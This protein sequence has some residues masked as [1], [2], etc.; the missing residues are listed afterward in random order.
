MEWMREVLHRVWVQRAIRAAL[1]AGLS[2]QAALMLPG[3]GGHAYYAPLGAVIAVH[4]TV[5]DS[6]AAAWRT[7][8][9]MLLGFVLAVGVYEATRAVPNAIT[10]ALIVVLAVGIEQWRTLR[11]QASWVSFAA[12]LML[13]VG[14]S[15]P[16]EYAAQYGGLTLL[17]A[18]IGVLVTSVLFP[19]MQLTTALRSIARARD[20]L[21]AHLEAI[22]DGLRRGELPAPDEWAQRGRELDDALDRMRAAE[23]LAERARRANPRARRWRGRAESIRVQSR[24]LDRVAVLV[25][26]LTMLVVEF[27]PHRHGL[28][29]VD[30]GT[31]WVLAEALTGLAQ[32]IRLPFH[33]TDAEPDERD[34][35]IDT[36]VGALDRLTRLLRTAEVADDEGF[37]ALGAVTVGMHRSL[38]TLQADV[39]RFPQAA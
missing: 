17:G 4:P 7:M 8:L 13:T 12:V 1:A 24:S 32:V 10:I 16:G 19:P 22:A 5:A 29:R 18:A 33:V 26:D 37:F 6:A 28:D 25:D 20:L 23:H 3:Q 2:W 31:G 11:E 36:A 38:R 15:D 21:A 34:R 35:A 30:G 27:Q 14:T 39:R 9:A